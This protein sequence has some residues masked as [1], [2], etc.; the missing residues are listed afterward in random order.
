[1]VDHM[2]GVMWALGKKKT[3]SKVNLFF[4]VT[5]ARQK[6]SKYYIEVYPRMG[7][8]LISIQI[9]DRFRKLW[10]FRKCDKRMDLNPE[11]ETSY[12]A[13]YQQAFLKYVE[14]EYCAKHRHVLVSKL[15]MI[16]SSKLIPSATALGSCQ[17][18]FDP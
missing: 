7:M 10:S 2:D 12:T 5:L 18:S 15:E 14:N 4:T 13:Q 8:V 11:D 1:M 16:L 9:L 6:L 17:T 3:E